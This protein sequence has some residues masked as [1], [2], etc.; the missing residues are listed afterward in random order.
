MKPLSSYARQWRE[1]VEKIYLSGELIVPVR[2]GTDLERRNMRIS[3]KS[4]GYRFFKTM[5]AEAKE[6][7]KCWAAQYVNVALQTSIKDTPEGVLFYPKKN[8]SM[9]QLISAA[10]A[11]AA[12]VEGLPLE[13]SN[14]TMKAIQERLLA[15]HV[16][17]K[18]PEEL[19]AEA[20][21]RQR[22]EEIELSGP[23]FKGAILGQMEK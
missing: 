11:E 17:S 23:T 6:D 21:E 16:N 13:N 5:Q 10:L 14:E 8:G 20:L 15:K 1:L 12:A 7:N 4:Q 18:T 2:V 9:S 3:L 22:R 19:A